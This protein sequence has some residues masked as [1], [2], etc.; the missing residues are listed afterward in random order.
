M[1][2]CACARVIHEFASMHARLQLYINVTLC[3]CIGLNCDNAQ[4]SHAIDFASYEHIS[5]FMPGCTQF[6]PNTRMAYYN[7]RVTCVRKR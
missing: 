3:L 1:C 6:I 7:A 4:R 5:K 2:M